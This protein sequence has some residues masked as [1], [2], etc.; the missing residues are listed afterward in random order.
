MAN[1]RNKR[2]LLT[3]VRVNDTSLF[4]ESEIKVEVCRAFPSLLSEMGD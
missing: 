3:K 1:V 4:E 2:N